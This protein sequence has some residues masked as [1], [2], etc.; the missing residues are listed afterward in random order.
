MLTFAQHLPKQGTPG[1]QANL[2][3]LWSESLGDSLSILSLNCS[4]SPF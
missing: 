1:W 2:N 4:T 3:V